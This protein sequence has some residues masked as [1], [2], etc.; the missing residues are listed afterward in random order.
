VSARP[1]AIPFNRPYATGRELPYVQEA[2]QNGHL[3]GNGP[4]S[5]RCARRLEAA[6]GA[7]RAL[8]TQACTGAL[9]MSALLA[10]IEPGDEVIMPS[11]TFVSTANAFV[12]R[13][14]VPV[15][16][17][18]RPDTLNLDEELVEDAITERTRAI[19]AVHYAG[20]G[21]EMD[22]LT[23]IAR[24]HDLLLVEDAAHALGATYEGRPLGA[25]GDLGAL[26]FHETKNVISGEG[27]ALLLREPHWTARAEILHEKGTNRRDFA[28]GRVEKYT[29]V[30]VGGSYAPSEINAAFLWA[31]LERAD[32]ITERRRGLWDAYH[33]A[34]APVEEAGRARRPVVPGHCRHNA[35]MYHLLV[36][37]GDAR[38]RFIDRL[39][40]RGVNAVFHY[41]P[42]HSSPAGRRY[43][44]AHGDLPCTE[45][46]GERL[47][48]LPLWVG[49]G[50]DDLDRVVEAAH[51]ALADEPADAVEPWAT[52]ARR[53]PSRLEAEA[54]TGAAEGARR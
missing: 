4:F 12:L 23:D 44:R 35:H 34:L 17:D 48:R 15:W 46:A 9:E 33:A 30:D 39:E 52:A 13:G 21:C 26:S 27:G 7:A 43:G 28:R 41:V 32:W 1:S 18:V 31:Q 49:L 19:V 53:R 36:S 11:F 10:G 47:V 8:L 50:T 3:S 51:R 37:G 20:V 25:L 5:A 22:A 24:R 38:T 16:V 54:V 6:T 42:L 14:G 29:W 2:I 45:R 40:A